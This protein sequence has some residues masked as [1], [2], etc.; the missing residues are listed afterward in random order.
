MPTGPSSGS[1]EPPQAT[2]RSLSGR[3][4]SRLTRHGRNPVAWAAAGLVL[5]G[6]AGAVV[7]ASESGGPVP[8]QAVYCGLV[9][10]AILRS[11]AATAGLPDKLPRPEPAPTPAAAPVATRA[12]A[13]AAK[14]AP[15]SRPASAPQP[16]SRPE[17]T[18]VPDPAPAPAPR[19]VPSPAWN[20]P[21]PHWPSP[22]GWPAPWRH[23]PGPVGGQRHRHWF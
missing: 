22:P 7:M 19:P 1:A 4:F 8:G 3:R 9:K 2:E 20:P 12:A 17:P 16:A 10:C 5:L 15:A 23:S 21:H 18:P 13:P 6:G 14:P 11:E